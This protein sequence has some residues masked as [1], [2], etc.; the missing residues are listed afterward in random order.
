MPYVVNRV[1][2]Y[3]VTSVVTS[4]VTFVVT[5]VVNSV[6]NTVVKGLVR[7]RIPVLPRVYR[8]LLVTALALPGLSEVQAAADI[9]R[10][11]FVTN[12]FDYSITHY[13]LD[14]EGRLHPNGMTYAVDKFPALLALHPSQ[15]WIYTASRTVDSIRGFSIDAITGQLSEIVGSPFDSKLRSPFYA[16]FHPSG[17]FFYLA[18]RGGGV[19]AY[20]VNPKTGAVTEVPGQ[21]FKSGERTRSL[22]VQPQGRFLYATNAYTNNISA[23]VINQDD[24]SLKDI[25]GSPFGTGEDG[26]FDDTA[27]NLPDVTTEKGALP[28]AI[29]VHPNGKFAYVNNFIGGSISSY[30]I[31]Q[32]SGALQLLGKPITTGIT[33]YP[34]KVHPNGRFLFVG[35]WGSNDIWVYAINPESGQLTEL[36]A[37]TTVTRSLKP[38]HLN[39]NRDGTRLYVTSVGSSDVAMLTVDPDSGRMQLQ[40]TTSAREGSF[41]LE[42]VYGEAVPKQEPAFAY[43]IDKEK[44]LL[45]SYKIDSG[46]GD[47]KAID[48][49]ATGKDPSAVAHDPKS[50]SVYVTNEGDD[51]VTAYGIEPKQG[52]LSRLI[53]SPR[54][55]GG[56]PNAIA[57]DANGWYVYVTN[58]KSKEM[59]MY[60]L[61]KDSAELAEILGSP[62]PLTAVPDQIVLDPMARFAYVVKRVEKEISI[63]RYASVITAALNEIVDYGSPLKVELDV[64]DFSVD[65]DGRFALALD[66]S[67]PALA[68]FSIAFNNGALSPV[69]TTALEA[70]VVPVAFAMHPS[71]Q[72]LLL[73][74]EQKLITFGYDSIDGS[75]K[76]LATTPLSAKAKQ[77]WI[78]PSGRF[79]YV[80]LHDKNALQRFRFDVASGS[81]APLPAIELDYA[82]TAMSIATRRQ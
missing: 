65:N 69:T 68:V 6:V 67:Q 14:T 30:R 17:R 2:H 78:E 66:R 32:A 47:F 52:K 20:Q 64:V 9:S 53:G 62:I 72:H 74:A 77:L 40:Q 56:G 45:H 82:V 1:A 60:L 80:Q 25:A 79:V 59:F 13:R 28:Y 81:L 57:I 58:R 48:D 41:A 7:E 70:G 8:V 46:N 71:G 44:R 38:V 29:D 22:V 12:A 26:P 63:F 35:T 49:I 34:V 73:L 43:A 4:V 11:A 50:R 5:S 10:F 76:P 37:L 75:L 55:A 39:F 31:D 51:N 54:P 3:V 27:I 42:L 24:G 36:K 16:D 33:P 23:Y 18:G 61:H 21:P 15:K 19:G